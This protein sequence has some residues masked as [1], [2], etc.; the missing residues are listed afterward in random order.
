MKQP[1]RKGAGAVEDSQSSTDK[2]ATSIPALEPL[3]CKIGNTTYI[4]RTFFDPNAREGVM[5]QLWRL[6]KSD[7]TEL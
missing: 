5:D 6:M 3:E 4:V 2:S 7:G 1:M